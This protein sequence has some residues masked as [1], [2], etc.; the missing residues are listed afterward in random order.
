MPDRFGWVRLLASPSSYLLVLATIA[1]SV[2]KLR[3]ISA[4]EDVG[5]WPVYWLLA[6]ASDVALFL[7]FAALF[8]F[9]ERSY[10]WM[11]A[12]TVPLSLLIGG[13]G[14]GNAVFI[15]ITGEQLNWRTVSFGL[16]RMD[17]L[18]DI[19]AESQVVGPILIGGVVASMVIVGGA[20]GLLRRAGQP[21]HPRYGAGSRAAAA[22]SCAVVGLV[23]SL[24]SPS[25]RQYAL[26]RLHGSAVAR[27]YWGIVTGGDDLKY[28]KFEF[29]G[30]LPR[31]LVD[32]TATA[33]LG[34]GRRPNIVLI[35]L[36]STGR[37]ITTLGRA[38][39]P[40]RTPNLV[41]LA[42]RGTEVVTARAVI[43]HT[44]KSLWSM[45]CARL[46]F[47]QAAV[48]ETAAIA[49]SECLPE[50]LGK[51][52]WRTKFFQSA[53][54][55]FEDRPRTVRQMGFQG[56]MSHEDVGGPRLG[57]VAGDDE[58]LVDRLAEWL[59][60]APG[61]P[62]MATLLT[63]GPHHEYEL[64]ENARA[65]ATATHRPMTSELERHARM[66]EI[67]D[68]VIGRVVERLAE[69]QLTDTTI[70]VV[71]G[72]HGEGFGDKGFRQHA[73]NFYEEGLRVPWVMAGPGIPTRKIETIASLL[74]LTPT[75]L[76]ALGL[77]LSQAAAA[78]T[79]GRSL[80]GPLDP[81]RRL[82]FACLSECRGYVEGHRK[83]VLEPGVKDGFWFDLAV[84]PRE[85]K[86]RP[87]TD[88]IREQIPA[89]DALIDAHRYRANN[90]LLETNLYPPWTCPAGRPCSHPRSG[91]R[92][93]RP[94]R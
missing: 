92:R 35:V 53:V 36:E 94:P 37:D 43:P 68:M 84:D 83:I 7:G 70:V 11:L 38:D 55:D 85:A 63:S 31:S 45:H 32:D 4:I 80:L 52:G 72:D 5:A 18:R 30:Y 69:R 77:A 6:T 9:G 49:D 59:D 24:L 74:D 29:R 75:L 66:V 51:A 1:T 82:P 57:Y 67:A 73:N 19:V 14:I 23:I 13:F 78:S 21:L 50:L 76:D 10:R 15:W 90:V 20:L 25:P 81:A 79:P 89:L 39:A 47:M 2:A 27:T 34:A 46:P 65:H 71:V 87:L 91:E 22:L 88:E 64:T 56:F 26:R 12:F 54:G 42:Q 60:A 28:G 44:T 58:P 3:V 17:D 41:A 62:F 93:M 48:F 86:A 8:A 33:T 61:Q 16:M 40:A